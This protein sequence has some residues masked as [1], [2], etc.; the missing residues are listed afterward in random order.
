MKFL[1]FYRAKEIIEVNTIISLVLWSVLPLLNVYVN[2][3]KSVY[4]VAQKSL[5]V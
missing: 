1:N 4:R 3:L 2:G 5:D